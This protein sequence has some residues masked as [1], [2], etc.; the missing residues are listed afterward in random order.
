VRGIILVDR[1]KTDPQIYVFD[2]GWNPATY[3]ER[4]ILKRVIKEKIQ[5]V[6][7]TD[8]FK[9]IGYMGYKPNKSEYV[10]KV[11][12]T[13]AKKI[14]G[15]AFDDKLIS[16]KFKIINETIEDIDVYNK[17]TD[18]KAIELTIVEEMYL[19]MFD[20]AQDGDTRYFLNKLESFIIKL[21]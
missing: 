11:I 17:S 2:A 8:M 15:A 20:K 7:I 1:K 16:Q 13:T 18:M 3:E 19:R 5:Q 21:K 10:F 6:E 12:D 4:G 14:S 9:W